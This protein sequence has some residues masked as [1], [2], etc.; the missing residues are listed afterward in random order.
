MVIKKCIIC[1][2]E[3]EAKGRALCCSPE[4]SKI[5]KKNYQREYGKSDKRKE[6]LKKYE[7]SE[8]GKARNK[9]WRESDKGKATL[10]RYHQSDKF[11]SVQK[12]Y[13]Q[14]DKGKASVKKANKS[15][16]GKERQKRHKQKQIA[17]L[18]E[19][20]DGD[21]VLI[22]KDC[23]NTWMEREAKMLVWFNESYADGV[24]AKIK[25]TPVCEVT[26][27]KTND[28]IIHHLYSFNT[29]PELGNDPA[30][31]V[32]IKE[33]VHKEFHSIYGYGNNTPEQWMEFI[34]KQY[35][36]D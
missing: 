8:R 32:R 20:Y 29:H 12:K 23:P 15:I 3:F 27:E 16:K 14:S 33:E 24:I 22:L 19:K 30:N 7:Q 6:Y 2:K 11:K 5:N 10:K 13:R 31:M 18:N 1:G 28:L 9:K 21:L 4:C 34:E 36:G 26:G 25:S 17:E 35:G